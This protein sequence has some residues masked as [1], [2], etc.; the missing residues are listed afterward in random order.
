MNISVYIGRRLSLRKQD[1]QSGSP[2]VVVGVVGVALAIIIML[3][4]IA[5]V[6]GFKHEITDK[7][8]GFNSPVT[9]YAPE[10]EDMPSLTRGVAV[11]DTLQQLIQTVAP[12]ARAALSIRQ[13]AIFKTPTDFQGI[14]LKG[15]PDDPVD[16]QFYADNLVEG[17]LPDSVADDPNQVMVSLATAKKLGVK[18]SDKLTAHFLDNNSVRT[19]NLTIT[20]IF[21]T[22]FGDFDNTVAVTPLAMLQRLNKVDSLTGSSIEVYNV[23]LEQVDAVKNQL[24]SQLIDL[25][26][27]NQQNP[28]LYRVSNINDSCGLYFSWLDLLDTNVV[29]II[30]LM[31]CVSAITLISSLFILIL[32]RVHTIGVLKSIGATN[33]QIRGIFIYMAERLVVRGMIIGNVIAIGLMLAQKAWHLL[34]LDPDA[35]YLNYVPI[36]ISISSIVIV[37]VG[38]IVISW[39]VLILP[40]HL[41]ARLSPATTLRF[42]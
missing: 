22:H 12:G 35:Y 40:S 16:W 5:V 11:N 15:L 14:V 13:P 18:T 29:V 2:G 24:T 42:E 37:N 19:R 10:I 4:A 39:L 33:S 26:I 31:A 8:T 3:L 6:S 34:P 21:D 9:I 38:V 30:V 28:M 23:P 7:L 36:N 25:T 1:G 27:K 41:I 32:E 17:T 20:G